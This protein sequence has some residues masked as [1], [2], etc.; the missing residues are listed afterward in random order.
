M[1]SL[2]RYHV[3]STIT[4]I[5]IISTFTLTLMI[6]DVTTSENGSLQQFNSLFEALPGSCILLRNDAPRYTVLASSPEYLK[7]TGST[8]ETLIGKG[9]F[10]AF[11]G[12]PN[13]PTDT[14]TNDLKASLELVSGR[15]KPHHLPVQR[16]D[17]AGEDGVVIKR[18]W[19]AANKPVLSAEGEVAYIIHSAEEITEEI[20][21]GQM[22]EKMEGMQLAYNLF[23]QTPLPVSILKGPELIVEMANAPTLQLW[24]KGPEV[25]GLPLEEAVPEVKG[26]GYLELINEVRETGVAKQVYER[27]VTLVRNGRQEL[28]YINYIY[29]PYYEED[30]T[31]AVGVLAI[32]N[33]VTGQV[34]LRQKVEESEGR[35]RTLAESTPVLISVADET[36]KATYFNKGWTELTGR[37]VEELLH[38]GWADFLHPDDKDRFVKLYLDAFGIQG[39]LTGEFRVLNPKGEYRWLLAHGAPRY[40]T[41]GGFA[42]YVCAC[43]DITENKL[44]EQRLQTAL[45]QVRL[46]KEAAELGT[47]DMNME[48]GDMHWDERCRILFGISHHQPVSYDLDFIQ[49]LHP[50]DQQRVVE[51]VN[52]AFDKSLSNGDYDVEY[53]TVGAEDGIIRWVRAKGKVYFDTRDK[54]I[55]F[56]GSVLDITEQKTAIQKIERLVAERTYELGQA[57]AALAESNQDLSRSN[58]NLEQF[59]YAASHDL[60]EPIRKINFFANRLKEHLHDTLD[61]DASS[62]FERLET[63]TNRM[64]TLIDDLLTYSHISL[65][66]NLGD[67]VD[68]NDILLLVKEDLEL[69]IKEKGAEIIVG[70]L[71]VVNG[72]KRQLQQLFENLVSNS[73]KYSKPGV[74]LRINITA[75]IV[76][77]GAIALDLKG[78]DSAKQFHLIEIKD[79]GIGFQQK[80][81]ERIFNVFTR[82]H[83]NSEYKGSGVG[84]SIARK[85]VENH[86]GYIRAE[87]KENEGATFKVLLPVEDH[88]EAKP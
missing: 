43:T 3:S 28:S 18:Y 31:K 48:N 16:Y 62:Y 51:I 65:G 76:S 81:A 69:V 79:N 39:P 7:Q 12:N 44:V 4:L 23:N 66:A 70:A 26:Q 80:D 40:T 25:I 37:P 58:E 29:Q 67:V 6:Q 61:K 74:P 32:G 68:I 33:E 64:S 84:L 2:L 47:F 13:D 49:R 46:S 9:I 36:G 8:V 78:E 30:S 73:L 10:E 53:R 15:K 82:L 11:P 85:V 59:A 1:P 24:G 22:K 87:S 19:R 77:G 86:K 14:G 5:R 55:R 34:Q 20:L 27:P 63:S 21:M 52:N 50:D 71:P 35:F 83:G 42:G 88:A 72:H 75:S 57:N 41:D 54:P 38:F 56:I 60:K 45:E 17:V